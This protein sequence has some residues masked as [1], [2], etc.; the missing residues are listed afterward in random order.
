MVTSTPPDTIEAMKRNIP[1]NNIEHFGL[2]LDSEHIC[3]CGNRASG[4]KYYSADKTDIMRCKNCDG[5]YWRLS[6]RGNF[7]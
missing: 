4:S 1:D 2:D 7:W 3:E 6:G 5:L